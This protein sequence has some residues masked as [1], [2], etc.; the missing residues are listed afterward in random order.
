MCSWM[1]NADVLAFVLRQGPMAWLPITKWDCH[2]L[3]IDE[4]CL[5]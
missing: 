5:G 3:L 4:M 2:V 1:E